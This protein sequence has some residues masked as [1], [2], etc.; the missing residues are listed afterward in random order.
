MGNIHTCEIIL[1]L[2][3]WFR[4]CCFKIFLFL[5]QVAFYS[6]KHNHLCRFSRGHYE[7]HSSEII[8][9][10]DQLFKRKCRFKIFLF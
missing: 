4:R 5:A 9:D 10:L 6:S 2:D 7:D 1:N 8:F 3:K